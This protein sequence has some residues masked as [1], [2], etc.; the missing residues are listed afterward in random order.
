LEEGLECFLGGLGLEVR[1]SGAVGGRESLPRLPAEPLRPSWV[2]E[3][4]FRCCNK[5]AQKPGS[6]GGHSEVRSRSLQGHVRVTSRSFY[7]HSDTWEIQ[8]HFK[9]SSRSLQGQLK[10]SSRHFT[11]TQ[12]H[13]H[14]D[15]PLRSLQGD[16]MVTLQG[17]FKVAS[18]S[19]IHDRSCP[20]QPIQ[21]SLSV[22][23]V[24][25]SSL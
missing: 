24:H 4:V 14:F 20:P 13:G 5:T 22:P 19:L 8:G 12:I 3:R 6:L 23:Y 16:F 17:Q 21:K 7:G 1:G 10:V 15:V 9:V 11:I 25:C 2:S 18:R